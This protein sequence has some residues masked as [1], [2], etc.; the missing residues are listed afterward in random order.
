[1]GQSTMW[2]VGYYPMNDD[3]FT[4]CPGCGLELPDRRLAPAEHFNASGECL[5]TYFAF[6]CWTLVRQD[7]G[8]IHQHAVD[9]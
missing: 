7:P 2:Q 9:A 4:V 8:F 3:A 5:D 6:T 1:M